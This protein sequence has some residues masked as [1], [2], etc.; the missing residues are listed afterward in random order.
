V[1]KL[2]PPANP[3]GA[4]TETVLYTFRKNS[5]GQAVHGET[6]SGSLL[7][8]GAGNLF[9]T[10]E[11]GGADGYGTV[12][13]LTANG[14]ETVLYSFKGWVAG[15]GG[16]PLAGV[17]ADSE[18]NFYGTTMMGGS[19]VNGTGC[20]CGTVFKIAPDGSETILHSFAGVQGGDGAN[21]RAGVLLDSSGALY[22]TTFE[23]GTN[24]DS[25]GTV[26]KIA[27]DGTYSMLHSFRSQNAGDGACP[28]A[29]LIMDGAGNLYGTT[30]EYGAS[31]AGTVFEVKP[32]GTEVVLYSFGSTG[33]YSDGDAPMGSLI[34]DGKGNLY[35]TTASGG[36]GEG[37]GVVFKLAPGGK[38]TVLHA[39]AG[40]RGGWNP[41]AGLVME[42]G[43][44]FGETLSGGKMSACNGGCG[45]VFAVDQ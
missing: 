40:A 16:V 28:Y 24:P 34:A 19:I 26:F 44:L 22:G 33:D 42:N 6:P 32:D 35:G 3:G 15:D 13:K 11:S 30:T 5:K 23:G 38:E 18:G 8:D 21:P 27:A 10:T 31:D 20:N 7:L 12:F 45:L 2:A 37:W 17:A 9:G 1:F 43:H 29:G 4:W 36:G 14:T 41:H 39:F 25:Y